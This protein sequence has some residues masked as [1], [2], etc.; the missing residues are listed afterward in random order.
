MI[1]NYMKK[2]GIRYEEVSDDLEGLKNEYFYNDLIK[3][4]K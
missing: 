2:H 1:K 3:E 4:L